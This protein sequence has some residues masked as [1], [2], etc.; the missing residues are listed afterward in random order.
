MPRF[1]SGG[2]SRVQ[3]REWQHRAGDSGNRQG[4]PVPVSYGRRSG[5]GWGGLAW[6]GRSAHDGDAAP[7]EAP[8]C[9]D[10]ESDAAGS[11]CRTPSSSARSPCA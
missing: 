3:L 2:A 10:A 5:A 9:G 11:S 6:A 7:G 4:R 1:G 8:D